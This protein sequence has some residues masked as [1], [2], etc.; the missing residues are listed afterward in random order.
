M[1]IHFI[2]DQH[3]TGKL[4]KLIIHYKTPRGKHRQNTDINLS[5]LFLDPPLRAVEAKTKINKWDLIKPK[6]LLQSKGN[7]K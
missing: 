4:L 7:H 2:R 3:Y 1:N 5:N 6:K